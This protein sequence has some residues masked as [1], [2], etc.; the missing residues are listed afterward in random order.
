MNNFQRVTNKKGAGQLV[1]DKLIKISVRELV[2]F[3]L[4]AGDLVSSFAG[5]NRAVEGIRAHQKVRKSMEKKYNLENMEASEDKENEAEQILVNSK[6]LK[7]VKI[8]YIITEEKFSLE[9]NGR[10]DGVIEDGK[11]IIIHE[12][13][14]T[15]ENLQFIEETYNLLH[16]AQAKLYAYIYGLQ[17]NIDYIGVQLT[18]YHIDSKES[19]DFIKFFKLEEL[20]D[21]FNELLIKYIEWAKVVND[22][23]EKRDASIKEL[24]FPFKTYRKGQ[25]DLA[26]AVYKTIKDGGK[27]FA[28]APTG[29]GKTI[30]TLFPSI[31]AM[32]EGLTEK[33]FY[34]TA[35]TITRTIAEKAFE[36]MK[37]SGLIFKTVTITAKEKI[38]FKDEVNCDSEACEYAKGHFDRVNN[39]VCEIFQKEDSFTRESIEKYARKHNVCPFEFSLDLSNWSDSI[40]CDYNYAFDPNV[41]LRRFFMEGGGEYTLL[42]DEAHN[43]VDRAR[44]MFSA[45]IYKKKVLDLRNTM[46]DINK[47]IARSLSSINS[48]MIKLRKEC[49]EKE[50][51]FVLQ[52]ELPKE[53]LSLLRSFV[54]SMEIYLAE[55]EGNEINKDLLSFYFDTLTFI[56]T[57]EGYDER[58]ISYYERVGND[59]KLKLYCL[60]PSFLLKQALN[61]GRA[62]IFFSATLTPLDYFVYILGGEINSLKLRLESPFPREN[63]CLLLED[64]VSTKYRMRE[65]TYEK[66]TDMISAV[67]GGKKGNYLVFFPSYQYMTEVAERYIG[68]NPQN[69]VIVQKSMMTEEEREEYLNQFSIQNDNSLVGFAVM[70]GIFGEGIDLVGD[71]LVGAIVVGVGLPQICLE[72]DIIKEHFES[73]QNM[74]FEYA[75]VYPGMNKVLQAVG[76]VIRTEKDRGVVVLIDER[77]STNT[78]KKLYPKE[79]LPVTRI[80]NLKAAEDIIENFWQS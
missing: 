52:K 39:A 2:E 14:S 5:V 51:H 45:E 63:L 57:A 7:E 64:K 9:I 49:D 10:I 31:K 59:V 34:L 65:L 19:K 11:D 8:S 3:V 32:G 20:K 6:Y 1:M 17:N 70:G 48:H 46:K 30:A 73:T 21:F 67:T 38:C 78:Y 18:Y 35:K 79:W 68:K 24:Q 66:V 53:I 4:R 33:I 74:G 28:Q 50:E 13:K 41:Y 36:N 26:V 15:T 54:S 58:Y 80:Q 40:I 56:R 60:D 22:W 16:W 44:E 27:L 69:K 75:Y 62:G 12:I 71:R 76:R 55:E 72:R 29:I 25:R 42:I 77:F 43:L 61:R 47:E 37:A 23:Q